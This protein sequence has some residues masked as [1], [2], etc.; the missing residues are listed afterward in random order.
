MNAIIMIEIYVD[1]STF[2]KLLYLLQ[3]ILLTMH[4]GLDLIIGYGLVFRHE[5]NTLIIP[6]KLCFS[7]LCNNQFFV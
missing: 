2:I 5:I 4:F 7:Y 3:Y 1:L 6:F